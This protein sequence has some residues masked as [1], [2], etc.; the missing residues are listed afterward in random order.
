M[1]GSLFE[2]SQFSKVCFFAVSHVIV[3]DYWRSECWQV[4]VQSIRQF[5]R[6]FH[7]QTICLVFCEFRS[8]VSYGLYFSVVSQLDKPLSSSVLQSWCVDY[9]DLFGCEQSFKKSVVYW[10]SFFCC[11]QS[12]QYF[13]Q[14][15][16]MVWAFQRINKSLRQIYILQYMLFGYGTGQNAFVIASAQLFL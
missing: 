11:D 4:E 5:F 7:Q 9:F 13:A 2:L 1:F 3:P 10:Q 6:F 15:P 12:F 8:G 14:L 16:H